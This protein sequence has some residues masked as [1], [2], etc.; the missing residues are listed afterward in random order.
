MRN[1]RI[2]NG[3]RAQSKMMP[4]Q[5]HSTYV[6]DCFP[7][8]ENELKF[9]CTDQSTALFGCTEKQCMTTILIYE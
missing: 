9:I 4:V 8:F 5:F 1:A 2:E 3:Q 6:R 7:S